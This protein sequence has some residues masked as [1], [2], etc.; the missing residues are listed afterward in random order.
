MINVIATSLGRVAVIF[1]V[2]LWA[3]GVAWAHDPGLSAA[4]VRIGRTQVVVRLSIACSDMSRVVPLDADCGYLTES[5]LALARPHLEA[6]GRQAIELWFA[7]QRVVPAAVEAVVDQIGGIDLQIRFIGGAGSQIKIR[8]AAMSS[9]PRGHRQY[10]SV[11]DARGDKL[12]ETL[13][14]ASTDKFELAIG[15]PSIARM[16]SLLQF[17]GLG[18]EHI[19][20]GYDHLVFLLGLLVVGAGFRDVAK[21]ITSFTAAHS[22]TLVL[23]TLNLVRIPP[24]VVEPLIALSIVYVGVEN[25]FR[26]DL[27]WRWLLTFGFGLIHGFGFASALRDLGIGSAGGAAL[28][29]VSFNVGVE[30]GQ[31]GVAVVVLPLIWKFSTRPAFVTTL[32]PVCSILISIA[33]GFWLIERIMGE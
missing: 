30:L 32:A 23:S 15:V 3:S 21:I 13:L 29:L 10:L 19:L 25:I 12:G 14:D 8:S 22:I 20:T 7:D 9:L 18:L 24:A 16:D 28:P 6:F 27:K 4:E 11:F 17:L 1:C 2:L 33:G 5:S 31:L 26:R